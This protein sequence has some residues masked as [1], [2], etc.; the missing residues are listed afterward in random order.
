MYSQ[1]LYVIHS[2]SLFR[3]FLQL[4]FEV[5]VMKMDDSNK[6]GILMLE[7][8]HL[9]ENSSE[10]KSP[11]KQGI[12][13]IDKYVNIEIRYQA[14]CWKTKQLTATDTSCHI[15]LNSYLQCHLLQSMLINGFEVRKERKG[16]EGCH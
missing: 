8:F 16:V 2:G 9:V 15:A 13:R 1:K 5:T 6:M 7:S 14:Q 4:F 12:V 11:K 3:Y 10:K